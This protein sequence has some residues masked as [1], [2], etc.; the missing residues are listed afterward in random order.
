MDSVHWKVS[1]KIG[2]IY[3]ESNIAFSRCDV[4]VSSIWL[5]L[6][7]LLFSNT[8]FFLLNFFMNLQRL[9]EELHP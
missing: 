8:I 7:L 4:K 9:K 2:D 3:H 5:Y 6:L 1:Y